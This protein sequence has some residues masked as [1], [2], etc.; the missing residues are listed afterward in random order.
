MPSCK[1]IRV[2]N[3]TVCVGDL[4]DEINILE[5]TI[6]APNF[7]DPD[8]TEDGL[9][10]TESNIILATFAGIETNRGYKLFDGVGTNSDQGI[11]AHT[12]TFFTRLTP[13]V[14]P[15]SEN[16]IEFDSVLYEII[17]VIDLDELHEFLEIRAVKK[18]VV[19]LKANQA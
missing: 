2:K 17:D 14:I 4:K 12:H 9:G 15:T 11:I 1:R 13:E 19:S 3:R 7:G 5:R 16:W 10:F 8:Y 6:G 18:G